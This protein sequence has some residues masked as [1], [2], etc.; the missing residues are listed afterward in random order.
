M[1][2]PF[3][4]IWQ[5]GMLE[6]KDATGE[7]CTLPRAQDLLV[8][9]RTQNKKQMK[10][11]YTTTVKILSGRQTW[12]ESPEEGWGVFRVLVGGQTPCRRVGVRPK[13]VA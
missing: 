3:L 9:S 5:F 6:A 1:W 2:I 11:I 7:G 13:R 10:L 8:L 12:R 4:C